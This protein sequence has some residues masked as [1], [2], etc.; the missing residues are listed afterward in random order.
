MIVIDYDMGNIRSVV[1]ALE[2]VGASVNVT[3]DTKDISKEKE[4]I[5][6]PGV[7]AFKRGMVNLRQLGMIDPLKKAIKNAADGG[8]PFLGICIG[9]QLL[10]TQS[11]EHGVNSG[12]GEIKGGVKKFQ[13]DMKIPHMGW[14]TIR[15][16][17]PVA[18]R[19]LFDNVL[20]D[21]YFL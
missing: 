7:G 16:P 2:R 14:N 5:V 10:F 4:A 18:C 13:G 11:E 3:L 6:L 20:E 12:L 19:S 8:T 15:H 1:K 9:L 21:S 17:S